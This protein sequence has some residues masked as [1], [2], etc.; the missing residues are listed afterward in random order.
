M[1][2]GLPRSLPVCSTSLMPARTASLWARVGTLLSDRLKPVT[3][4]KPVTSACWHSALSSPK[5]ATRV[6]GDTANCQ[7]L[8]PPTESL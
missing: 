2:V 3:G 7:A 5:S 6:E 1:M 4:S 8:A